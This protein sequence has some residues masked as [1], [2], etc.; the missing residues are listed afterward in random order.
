MCCLGHSWKLRSNVNYFNDKDMISTTKEDF[1]KV[2]LKAND[3]DIIS[4]IEGIGSYSA[5]QCCSSF[6]SFKKF[7]IIDLFL[8]L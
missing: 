2:L 4:N 7:V 8:Y 3:K 1:T 6:E 5:K